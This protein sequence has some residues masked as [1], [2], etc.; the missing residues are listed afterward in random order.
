M[1]LLHEAKQ[2]LAPHVGIAHSTLQM[3]LPPARLRRQPKL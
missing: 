3:E 1:E 2:R